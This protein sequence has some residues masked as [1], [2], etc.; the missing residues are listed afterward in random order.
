M[1]SKLLSDLES[2]QKFLLEQKEAL[3]ETAQA[4]QGG[5]HDSFCSRLSSMTLTVDEATAVT[6]KIGQRP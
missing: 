6:S 2:I 3:G 1:A 5:Q 4:V